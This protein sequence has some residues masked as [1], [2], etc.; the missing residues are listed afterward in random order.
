M[1]AKMRYYYTSDHEG[2]TREMCNS[3][4][5]I[6]A[7]YSYDPYGRVTLVSGTR[8]KGDRHLFLPGADGCDS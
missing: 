1:A 2:S 5:A 6:V 7:R 8:A 4:G 3:S